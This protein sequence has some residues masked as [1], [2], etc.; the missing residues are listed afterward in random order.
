M[1]LADEIFS[2]LYIYYIIVTICFW[3]MK[4][5]SHPILKQ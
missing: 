1:S 5:K 2:V 4:C 3:Q